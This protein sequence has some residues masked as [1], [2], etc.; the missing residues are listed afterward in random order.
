MLRRMA[1]STRTPDGGLDGDRGDD[2]EDGT[3][4]SIT[5]LQRKTAEQ[6]TP[7]TPDVRLYHRAVVVA[8]EATG[9]CRGH[10]VR[11]LRSDHASP[12]VSC[13]AKP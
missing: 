2:D 13:C 7:P 5:L 11:H 9:A 3:P 6:R 1:V 8:Q 10:R 4:P 12:M